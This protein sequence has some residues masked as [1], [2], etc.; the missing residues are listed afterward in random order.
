MT[1]PTHDQELENLK[2][3]I[4]D[5]KNAVRQWALANGGPTVGKAALAIHFGVKLAEIDESQAKAIVDH[6]T[7]PA[8]DGDPAAVAEA[9]RAYEEVCREE[10]RRE[11]AERAKREV[12]MAPIDDAAELP[13]D[14]SGALIWAIHGRGQFDGAYTHGNMYFGFDQRLCRPWCGP[15]ESLTEVEDELHCH[16]GQVVD[17]EIPC[18]LD[19]DRRLPVLL[20]DKPTFFAVDGWRLL[21]LE[22]CAVSGAITKAA[23]DLLARLTG[24]AFAVGND[25]YVVCRLGGDNYPAPDWR[26]AKHERFSA[27][28]VNGR[29]YLSGHQA[30]DTSRLIWATEECGDC[31]EV[32]DEL[33]EEASREE[34]RREAAERAKR[35]ADNQR[36]RQEEADGAAH[37]LRLRSTAAPRTAEVARG[38][39]IE[40]FLWPAKVGVIG[41]PAKSF[42]SNIAIELGVAV[43]HGGRFLD[44]APEPEETGPV[45]L[46][47]AE[48]D[49]DGDLF[50]RI[51]AVTEA[52]GVA[53]T[54]R[55]F[56]SA[57]LPD[58]F[59]P[60]RMAS[61]SAAVIGKGAKLVIIDPCYQETQ[62]VRDEASDGAL[63]DYLMPL[64]HLAKESGAAVMLVNHFTRGKRH[65]SQEPSLGDLKG[66][67]YEKFARQWILVNKTKDLKDGK[68]TLQLVSGSAGSQSHCG[69]YKLEIDQGGSKP[70]QWVTHLTDKAAEPAASAA[71]GRGPTAAM[72]AVLDS[73]DATEFRTVAAIRKA[74]NLNGSR[75]KA[76]IDRLVE[77]DAI[78]VG[79]TDSGF[80]GYRKSQG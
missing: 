68:A 20:D 66:S 67:A 80:T 59:D 7:D 73:L 47:S 64:R 16:G 54:G 19:G 18:G 41:G 46:F 12:E 11:A 10:E 3:T 14:L 70:T 75:A 63:L 27:G 79:E 78:E 39:L 21:V 5:A 1:T 38:P 9:K 42:K 43:A 48:F 76:A 60:D 13:R 34:E 35:E 49:D 31:S 29:L 53:D 32:V 52:R 23:H 57:E 28:E 40:G 36:R 71:K 26:T 74:S 2:V 65:A 51:D 55:L 61:L 22:K 8:N 15:G 50:T 4:D 77:E 24:A 30:F 69:R 58:L 45:I 37:V 72:R 25:V 33:V 56:A 17:A 6:F 44:Y 62:R